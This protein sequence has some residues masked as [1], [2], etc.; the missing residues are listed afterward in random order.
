ML[1]GVIIASFVSNHVF[2]NKIRGDIDHSLQTAVEGLNREIGETI[3]H[4]DKFAR[5]F[6]SSEEIPRLIFRKNVYSLNRLMESQLDMSVVDTIT[7]TDSAGNL[8]IRP[9][10]VAGS[11]EAVREYVAA[12]LKGESVTAVSATS[13]MNL[14]IF[15]GVPIYWN[16]ELAGTIIVGVDIGAPAVLD[17]LS[18]MYGAE[19][20]IFFG[21]TR[22]GTTLKVGDRRD[23]GVKA[24]PGVIENVLGKG[25]SHFDNIV[26]SDGRTVR[27]TYRPFVFNG[28]T[29]G[30]L[31]AG[32]H[33]KDLDD[34]IIAAEFRVV[35]TVLVLILLAAPMTWMFSLRISRLSEEHAKQEIHL[36][37]MMN[38]SPDLVLIFDRNGRFA[39]CAKAFLDQIESARASVL[40]RTFAEVLDGVIPQP[41]MDRLRNALNSA[42]KEG[43]T[44]A[45]ELSFDLRGEDSPHVY[46]IQISPMLDDEA[47]IIG[48]MA[49]F[50]DI[51]SDIQA[52]KAEAAS[53]AKTAFLANMSHEIRTPLNAIIGLSEIE[54]H[55]DIPNATYENIVKIHSSGSTLLGIINDVLDISKIESGKFEITEDAY[56]LASMISD[57]VHQNIPRI[58]SKPINFMLEMDED[59]PS[60]LFGDELRVKQ[61]LNNLLSNA[62]KYT[63]K[64]V[65]PLKINCSPDGSDRVLMSYSVI[66]TGIGIKKGDMDKLFSQYIQLDSYTNRQIEGTGLGLSITKNLIGLM[67][68]DIEVRSEY[69]HGAAFTVTIP[70]GIADHIPIGRETVENLKAF[71][72]R[73]NHV[74]HDFA[75]R[76]TPWGKVLVVDDV[77]TNQEV[78]RGLMIPYGLT[79]HCASSGRQAV[80]IVRKGKIRYDIIFMDHMMPEMD[81]VEAVRIIRNEVGTEY[82]RTVPIIALTANALAGNKEMLLQNGFEAYLFKP[83][84][85]AKLDS[86]LNE[87]IPGEPEG[88]VNQA[89][90]PVLTPPGGEIA[91]EET[92]RSEVEGTLID[93]L[94]LTA[95]LSNFAGARTYLT[96]LRSYV[97]HTPELLERIKGV[98]AENLAEYAIT[99]HGIKGSSF[100]ILAHKIGDMAQDLERAAKRGDLDAVRAGNDIFIQEAMTLIAQVNAMLKRT[101]DSGESPGGGRA[102]EPDAAL[103]ERLLERT[104]HYDVRGMEGIM[105]EL[106][107]FSYDRGADLIA[108]LREKI[109]SLDYEEIEIRLSSL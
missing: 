8:I 67:N 79:V 47:S 34:A 62:F 41:E 81:G 99:I 48:V 106:E 29:I 6:G 12:A 66:D 27:T 22:V 64:G 86:L 3:I 100:G 31:A 17:G 9:R 52:R 32:I 72:M 11:N 40:G 98:N 73:E 10:N 58:A 13:N 24:V 4:I 46:S 23:T 21:D 104:V 14:A 70:Q 16:S 92:L 68:G 26:V 37:L 85:V 43:K 39:D 59:I 105:A 50:H 30:V 5:V 19:L 69:G 49:L 56:D 74:A 97:N 78:A 54:L 63:R 87:W 42:G 7:I 55:N 15:K 33:T 95:G 53:Q 2:V 101:L 44:V 61:I 45:L 103:L 75:R 90:E 91:S 76:R 93:G 80:E 51:S 108:W 96:I 18:K 102:S 57:A 89:S 94:N 82:A 20:S 25:R 109:D 84:D 36:G 60:K 1:V 38:N 28:K 83:V 71:R 77:I 88:F 35:L 65:V 107:S